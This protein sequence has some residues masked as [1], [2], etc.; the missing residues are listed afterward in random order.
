M[1]RAIV[2]DSSASSKAAAEAAPARELIIAIEPRA[3]IIWSGTRAQILAEL[4]HIDGTKFKNNESWDDGD[5]SYWLL[6]HRPDGMS[7]K[8]WKAGDRDHW[9]LHQRLVIDEGT[10]FAAARIHEKR[11]ALRH[12]L[13]SQTPEA[14]AQF[15][16]AYAARQDKA[17]CRFMAL[18][19]A[20]KLPRKSMVSARTLEGGL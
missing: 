3:Q 10:G 16:L 2:A 17:Y 8:E 18:A 1:A 5:F 11:E 19:G 15:S 6:Q 4:P 14:G 20:V 13:W 12:E 9:S 7:G